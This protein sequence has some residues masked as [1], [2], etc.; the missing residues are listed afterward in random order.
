MHSHTALRGLCPLITDAHAYVHCA[1]SLSLVF[2]ACC[3][4]VVSVVLQRSVG[5]RCGFLSP[6]LSGLVFPG[7]PPLDEGPP[8][9]GPV[10]SSDLCSF[11]KLPRTPAQ[12]TLSPPA[13]G[14]AAAGH[15]LRVTVKMPA[16]S[17]HLSLC[18]SLCSAIR[19]ALSGSVL[20]EGRAGASGS[21]V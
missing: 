3:H 11:R 17:S 15:G 20:V 14:S 7:R 8:L 16:C 2:A 6:L 19:C 4:G 12:S 5:R 1:H 21:V 10:G 9:C 18:L 13:E